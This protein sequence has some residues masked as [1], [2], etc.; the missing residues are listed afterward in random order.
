MVS[1]KYLIE[2]PSTQLQTLIERGRVSLW[3]LSILTYLSRLAGRISRTDVRWIE[4]GP[5]G[6]QRFVCRS[7]VAIVFIVSRLVRGLRNFEF[8]PRR[9][10]AHEEETHGLITEFKYFTRRRDRLWRNPRRRII[11]QT[12]TQKIPPTCATSFSPR[13]A[14]RSSCFETRQLETLR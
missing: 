1:L 9:T 10:K 3:H 12:Q 5:L 13:G 4:P 6:L 11:I 14:S 2:F 8:P 7:W